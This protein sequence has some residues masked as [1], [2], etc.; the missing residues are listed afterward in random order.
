MNFLGPVWPEVSG[1]PQPS[2]EPGS[3]VLPS[4][5]TGS[6]AW[7]AL[8]I[9]MGRAV[10]A[11]TSSPSGSALVVSIRAKDAQ[12]EFHTFSAALP[13]LPVVSAEAYD[14]LT[15]DE[16]VSRRFNELEAAELQREAYRAVSMRNWGQLA[17]MLDE[18]ARRAHD[19]PWLMQTVAV[20]RELLQQ[21]DQARLEKELMYSSHSLS[22]RL[23]GQDELLSFSQRTESEK[24]AFL[25]RKVQQGRVSGTGR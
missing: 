13:R 21:R 17:R 18:I 11:Q 24:A 1:N 19:N 5:A 25:R 8:S 9:P 14:A 22:S 3:W 20:L 4:L 6:E 23:T 2:N 16:L 7:V 15:A 12:G 10:Y